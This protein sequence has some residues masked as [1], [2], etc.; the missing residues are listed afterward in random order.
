MVGDMWH[1]IYRIAVALISAGELEV[2][3]R[4]THQMYRR[5]RNA[6]IKQIAFKF[7][8]CLIDMDMHVGNAGY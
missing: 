3:T 2:G 4:W 7:T 8:G 1:T 5:G 6:D